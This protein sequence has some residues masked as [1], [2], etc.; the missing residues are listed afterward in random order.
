[1]QEN[2]S[3]QLRRMLNQARQQQMGVKKPTVKTGLNTM[4]ILSA[5]KGKTTA[6]RFGLQKVSI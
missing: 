1:M 6:A 2:R 5:G 3:M 4:G